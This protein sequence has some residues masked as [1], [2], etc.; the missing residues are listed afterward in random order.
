[1]LVCFSTSCELR[2]PWGSRLKM[3][4]LVRT[5]LEPVALSSLS[6]SIKLSRGHLAIDFTMSLISRALVTDKSLDARKAADN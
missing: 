3:R 4:S 2:R 5:D 6:E 1:M